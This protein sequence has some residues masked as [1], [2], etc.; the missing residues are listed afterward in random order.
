[1]VSEYSFGGLTLRCLGRA[2]S[3]EGLAPPLRVV[4]AADAVGAEVFFLGLVFFL[5][6]GVG[7]RPTFASVAPF[8]FPE[9]FGAELGFF[10]IFFV[11]GTGACACTSGTTCDRCSFGLG[12]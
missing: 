8:F 2:S 10:F 11:G 1:M 7:T 5:V 12:W 3:E 4:A 6:V 9:L